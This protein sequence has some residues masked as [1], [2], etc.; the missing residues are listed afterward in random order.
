MCGIKEVLSRQRCLNGRVGLALCY[1][2]MGHTHNNTMS[3]PVTRVSGMVLRAR[4]GCV[5]YMMG[6]DDD[7]R[8]EINKW[9]DDY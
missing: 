2:E 8:Y 1:I 9:T 4:C 5:V 7:S 6:S 3:S